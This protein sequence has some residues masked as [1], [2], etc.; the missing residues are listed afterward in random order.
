M[1]A[2]MVFS[3]I[4]SI[5]LTFE[6]IFAQE[7]IV[8]D[9]RISGGGT[10]VEDVNN[11]QNNDVISFSVPGPIPV[12]GSLYIPGK[13]LSIGTTQ[14]PHT[15]LIGNNTDRIFYL[16]GATAPFIFSNLT[17]S[18]GN[19]YT[20]GAVYA[21]DKDIVF[22]NGM[23]I[24][25]NYATG[26]GGGVYVARADARLEDG[27]SFTENRAAVS[28]GGFY[29]REGSLFSGNNV[30]LA[31][32]SAQTGGGGW[33]G[34]NVQAGSGV[35]ILD[36]AAVGQGGGLYVLGSGVV[37]GNSAR[38]ERNSSQI[39]SGGGLMIVNSTFVALG[40][41]SRIVG[42]TAALSGGGAFVEKGAFTLGTSALVA[43]NRA[44]TNVG[45]GFYLAE[46][47]LGVGS[48]AIF[49]NN[50]AKSSGGAIWAR[51]GGLVFGDSVSFTR[52]SANI[53]AGNDLARGGGGIHAVN[54]NVRF[55][56]NASFSQNS[57][58]NSG[59]GI[60]AE[61]GTVS[62]GQGAEFLE[63]S[64]RGGYGGAIAMGSGDLLVGAGASFSGNNAALSGGAVFNLAGR[65]EFGAGSYFANN[66]SGGAGG[67]L[68]AG[69]GGIVVESAFTGNR[70]VGDGG[71]GTGLGGAVY[72]RGDFTV[73]GGNFTNA[74]SIPVTEGVLN[75]GFYSYEY[76]NLRW[77]NGDTRLVVNIGKAKV[78]PDFTCVC[79]VTGPMAAVLSN[80]GSKLVFGRAAQR[81]SS[82][83]PESGS[84]VDR[85]LPYDNGIWLAGSASH[86]D[87]RDTGGLPGYDLNDYTAILG[88]DRKFGC[89]TFAGIAAAYSSP[90]FKGGRTRF[91]ADGYRGFVYGGARLPLDVDLSLLAGFGATRF[92]Q[93]RMSREEVYK[94][95]YNTHVYTA[96]AGLARK[97]EILPSWTVRPGLTYEFLRMKS[98]SY[99]ESGGYYALTLDSLYQS[100]HRVRTGVESA[101][102]M[103]RQAE[104][105]AG[106]WYQGL[107][108]DRAMRVPTRF[109]MDPDRAVFA[110]AGHSADKDSVVLGLKC[111]IPLRDNI[112]VGAEYEFTAGRRSTT[113]LGSAVLNISW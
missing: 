113:H 9:S 31:N 52:N 93:Q 56:N 10:L 57:A 107:Y 62:F 77:M 61:K 83:Q 4:L 19:G 24:R 12:T 34:Q 95:K 71:A 81:L 109:T 97:W 37:F 91:D 67:A 39:D 68:F 16:A 8:T 76:D 99:A 63:N 75:A 90:N 35:S 102:K 2:R 3:C 70:S 104:L 100:F 21:E 112:S 58:G 108:G 101:W 38:V 79:S 103:G 32:N 106:V 59:G 36:N 29:V 49:R 42:N 44:E 53:S 111:S 65:V 26:D 60:L 50:F 98:D 45:G 78:N 48:G 47:E 22:Q 43:D 13:S 74:S 105:S 33:V 41:D 88:Y 94:A 73:A 27:T 86:T 89:S 17:L 110:N 51:D 87:Y 40:D 18:G 5:F 46:S 54:G 96:G 20:G 7:F 82:A 84:A 28:G 92:D 30:T 64:S 15:T 23:N 14:S 85:C 55:G 66:S 6:L 80:S 72:A 69:G 1:P 11:S 25:S